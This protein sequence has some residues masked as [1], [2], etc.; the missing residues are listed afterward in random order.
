MR[1]RIGVVIGLDLDDAAAGAFEQQRRADQIGRDLMHAA[2]EKVA[3]Q[4]RHASYVHHGDATPRG[5]L[6]V[7]KAMWL[8]KSV[9]HAATARE[10]LGLPHCA[11]AGA[12]IWP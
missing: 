8:A 2:F 9:S 5:K 11:S 10:H 3:V 7:K 6:F 12:A 1:R 4:V